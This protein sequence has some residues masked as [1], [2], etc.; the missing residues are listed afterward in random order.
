MPAP[1]QL[2]RVPYDSAHHARRMGAGPD[3]LAPHV[4]DALR[5]AGHDVADDTIDAPDGFA[6]EASTGF[7]LARRLAERVRAAHERGWRPLTLAGNCLTS[8]GTASGVQG[9]DDDLAVVWL[10]AHGDLETPDTSTSGFVDGMALSA[11]TG[12]AWRALAASVPGFRAVP[13]DRVILV[14]ARDVSD[15]ERRAIAEA[16]ITWIDADALRDGA[17]ALG[18]ALDAL[19]ARG[20]RRAYV[21]LDLDVHDP[22]VARVNGYP[23]PDG[24]SAAVV[25]D[26]V[27][28]VGDRLAIVA[29]AL[30]AYDPAVDPVG[31]VPALVRD[32]TPLLAR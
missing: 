22:S 18:P 7:A 12:R 26:V 17:S 4:V 29:A 6:T 23:A 9:P 20:V 10:D 28:L 24:L 3:A 11:L 5:A 32:L 2:L 16:G 27:R 15:A 25:R 21:H 31:Q 13:G 8:L 14:G 30:T 1:V 19:A